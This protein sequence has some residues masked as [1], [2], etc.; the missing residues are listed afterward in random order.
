MSIVER[1]KR[2]C[3]SP[4]TE[5]PV[6]AAE[7][8]SLASLITGYV[9]PLAAINAI[10]GM[11]GSV[12][13]GLS[14]AL[15]LS[16]AIT[17]LLMSIVMVVVLSTII[18]ALAPTFGAEKSSDRAA[19]VAAYAPTPAWIAGIAQI[20]PYLGTVIAFIGAL[21][22]LYLLYLGLARVMRSPQEKVV[23]YTVVVVVCALVIGT[24]VGFVAASIGFGVGP[25]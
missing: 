1:A 22:A 18:D 3:V 10:A 5:W 8:T 9:L 20:I 12:M 4:E 13:S 14:I 16:V 6:I 19:K 23:G 2:I 25:F 24:V 7:S 21:Y 15:G 11:I 17:A